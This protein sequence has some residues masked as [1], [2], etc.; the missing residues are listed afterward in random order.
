MGKV[1]DN[2]AENAIVWAQNTSGSF[3]NNRQT[4]SADAPIT[5]LPDGLSET[6]NSE[7]RAEHINR[8][9]IILRLN[10]VADIHNVDFGINAENDAFHHGDVGVSQPKSVVR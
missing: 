8:L 5:L 9:L 7:S 4:I 2:I 6:E 3:Q 1:I 10:G